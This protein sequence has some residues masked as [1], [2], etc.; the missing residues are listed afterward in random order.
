[1]KRSEV[2]K[3]RGIIEKATQLLD[4]ETA[5]DAVSLHPA[6]ASEKEYAVNFKVR[7][8]GVLYRCLTAH[9]AQ[10]GWTPANAP[11]LWAEVLV[12]EGQI[13]PWQQPDSTNPYGKGDKVTHNGSVWVSDVD[14]NVW[15]PGV[16]GWSKE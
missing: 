5:L 4:D 15:E 10:E 9:R 6:W 13:L 16:Y 14:N 3:L 2:L 8:G 7:F 1:M 12:E 11:S